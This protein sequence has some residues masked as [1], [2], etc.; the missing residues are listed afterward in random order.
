MFSVS[1]K[2]H[3]GLLAVFELVAN[4]DKRLVQIKDI[5]ESRHVP[6]NYLEQILNRLL[7]FG[8]V[9]SVRGNRGGYEL[10]DHPD[11]I[12]LLSVVE[13]LEGEIHLAGETFNDL[14][15]V[16][17]IFA[18]METCIRK[19]LDIPLSVIWEKQKQLGGAIVYHI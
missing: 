4:Y 18:E 1:A 19:S 2:S 10:G 6:K 9:K 8:I 13:A 16:N 5:V 15:A 17:G 12:T 7:K 3:Y 11:K 14:Q